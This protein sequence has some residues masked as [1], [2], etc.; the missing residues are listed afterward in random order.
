MPI[1]P[2]SS[3]SI[4]DNIESELVSSINKLTNFVSG[5]FNSTLLDAYSSQIRETEIKA[6]AVQ[7]SAYPEYAGKEITQDDL[8]ELGVTTVDPAEVNEYVKTRDLDKLAKL[9]GVTREDGVRATGSVVITVTDDQVTIP[10]GFTVATQPSG[11]QDPLRFF[12]DVNESGAIEDDGSDT[13]KPE[14]GETTVSVPIIAEFTGE[15]FNVGSGSITFIPSQ[16]PGIISVTNPAQITGGI[17]VE[18]TESLR[19]RTKNAVFR[20]SGGGTKE[21]VIGA[22]QNETEF[23]ASLSIRENFNQNP[24]VVE[25]IADVAADSEQEQKIENIVDRVRPVGVKHRVISPTNIKLK[26]TTELQGRDIQPVIIEDLVESYVDT[27]RFGDLFSTSVLTSRLLSNT[28][29]IQSV[30]ATNVAFT[31][32]EDER[33][34]Y[35]GSDTIRLEKSPFSTITDEQY[36]YQEGKSSYSLMFDDVIDDSERVIALIDGTKRLLDDSEAANEYELVDS[37]GDGRLD[38]VRINTDNIEPDTDSVLD[39]SYRHQNFSID[40][41]TTPSQTFTEGSDYE[42]ADTDGDG[43]IDGIRWLSGGERPTQ[44]EKVSVTYTTN[45]SLNNDYLTENEEKLQIIESDITARDIT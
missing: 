33:H 30:T 14:P 13:V 8:D 38:T 32:I 7:L 37:S 19:K 6:L 27:I 9:V 28:T 40:S 4:F 36:R 35:T 22:V 16:L 20:N 34:Q 41:V 23:N 39:F 12:C 31:Q 43:H 11:A 29:T 21:G 10:E 42:I 17:D 1:D 26:I 2:R 15:Q 3:D 5:T 24:R 45:R 25:L 18:S 44:G